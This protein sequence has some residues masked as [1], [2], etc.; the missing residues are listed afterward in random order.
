MTPETEVQVDVFAI[1]GTM[2][3]NTSGP[4][5]LVYNDA[6]G[7]NIFGTLEVMSGDFLLSLENIINTKLKI[8]PG[9]QVIFNGPVADFVVHTSAYYSARTSLSNIIPSEE[10]LASTRTPVNAYIHLDGQLMKYP[11]IDFSFEMPNAGQE[12][13]KQVFVAIDTSNPQNRSKQFFIFLLTN[14]FMPDNASSQ[15]ISSTMESGGI[16]IVTNMVNN[17]LSRQMKHGGIGIV[18][19]NGNEQTAREYGLNANVQFL[20]DRMIF[21]TNIGYYDNSRI[22]NGKTGI[23]NFYGDFSLEY[24]ITQKGNWRVKVYNFNDQYVTDSYQK[25]PGV[26]LALMY[27]Q[28]FNNRKDFSEDFL[29]QVKIDINKKE[30]K[31]KNKKQR[32]AK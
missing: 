31:S 25:V 20:N 9:G 7:I 6:E 1:G 22:N 29:E 18:Y 14:Q 17:F 4:L 19:K 11:S 16:G 13:S 24:L 8:V 2:R 28:D 10:A 26:G 30:R 21:E 27:K 3:A 15:D 32:K 23:E 12:F 5:H